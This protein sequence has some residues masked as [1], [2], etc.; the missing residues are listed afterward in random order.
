VCRLIP[1]LEIVNDQPV[2]ATRWLT[3]DEN[4]LVAIEVQHGNT[5]A[6]EVM[7]LFNQGLIF[8]FMI[9]RLKASSDLG[10]H[11]K[12]LIQVCLF[13]NGRK[14]GGLARAVELYD[15]RHG[16][17]FSTYAENWIRSSFDREV[18]RIRRQR[19]LSLQSPVT[20]DGN[21]ERQERIAGTENTFEEALRT[22]D[23]DLLLQLLN[24]AL[25]TIITR[26]DYCGRRAKYQ[27]IFLGWLLRGKSLKECAQAEGETR[28]QG[29]LVKTRIV[30][31][32]KGL[33]RNNGSSAI[34]GQGGHIMLEFGLVV[35][36]AV[37]IGVIV[38]TWLHLPWALPLVVI[39][40]FFV[41][42]CAGN[43]FAGSPRLVF[44]VP[45]SN[46]KAESIA[47]GFDG[48]LVDRHHLYFDKAR[49]HV[50]FLA[51]V[52]RTV[53]DGFVG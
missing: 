12:D 35:C 20:T 6:R 26:G 21:V 29:S 7:L 9:R 34:F 39:P 53:R 41:A 50:I 2:V 38:I 27:R 1:W 17:A 11:R 5:A 30:E 46:A 42:R 31:A 33:I 43:S 13:G 48:T 22:I 16:T 40:V 25:D 14:V 37:F 23:E 28:A 36:V 10:S 45:L 19:E 44:K 18:I 52:M 8:R 51:G 24:L 49:K 32:M 15:P 47:D 4:K 3:A